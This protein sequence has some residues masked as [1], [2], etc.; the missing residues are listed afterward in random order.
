[1]AS[2]SKEW[3]SC[4][5]KSK[6]QAKAPPL[7]EFHSGV[8]EHPSR[9]MHHLLAIFGCD[10]L[11]LAPF[12]PLGPTN[13]IVLYVEETNMSVASPALLPGILFSS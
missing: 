6:K 10:I 1:M 2:P 8:E 9:G 7:K 13:N 12:S 5:E 3:R 4:T 11:E